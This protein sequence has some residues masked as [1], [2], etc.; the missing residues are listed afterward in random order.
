MVA[1][2]NAHRGGAMGVSSGQSFGHFLDVTLDQHRIT[3][4]NRNLTRLNHLVHL[5]DQLVSCSLLSLVR[6]VSV[7][8]TVA[9]TVR[10]IGVVI[11]SVV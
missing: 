1:E 7:G 9:L 2:R 4:L 6:A 3:L 10:R 5:V 11:N 8:V